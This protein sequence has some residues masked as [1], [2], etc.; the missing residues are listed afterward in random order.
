MT[1][2]ELLI[3]N[4]IDKIISNKL[5]NFNDIGLGDKPFFDDVFNEHINKFKSEIKNPHKYIS[6]FLDIIIEQTKFIVFGLTSDTLSEIFNEVLYSFKTWFDYKKRNLVSGDIINKSYLEIQDELISI[7]NNIKRKEK[8][9]K[10]D[11]VFENERWLVLRILSQEASCKYGSNT[12]WCI[13]AKNDN[14][15]TGFGY[16]EN[17]L[18]Y[19]VIDKKEKVDDDDVLYKM[20]ILIH[21][22]SRRI[23][24]WNAEDDQLT[25][26]KVN[27]VKRFIP[28]IFE[29]IGKNAISVTNAIFDPD[30]LRKFRDNR[31][32]VNINN[33]KI[34]YSHYYSN[35]KFKIEYEPVGNNL[36]HRII[37]VVNKENNEIT[38]R[39]VYDR[40]I[41]DPITGERYYEDFESVLAKYTNKVVLT[42]Q[43][44]I[45]EFRKTF[46]GLFKTPEVKNY[47]KE[48]PDQYF[49][50]IN[51]YS[52]IEGMGGS[53]VP[54]KAFIKAI[55]LLKEK[56][57]QNITTIRRIVDPKLQSSNNVKPLLKSLYNLG[58][59]TL[60][61]RGRN[62]MIVPTPKLNKTPINK[63]I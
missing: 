47:F 25:H 52:D 44:L 39:F 15:F 13:S 54:Q 38:S 53:K 19:F 2:K 57:E 46:F 23:E 62:V 5:K 27:I 4:E 51:L 49:K 21:K 34:S 18:I 9:G 40:V 26:D 24:V 17:N 48:N 37:V 41:N 6:K 29:A 36:G 8:E 56:G 43:N 10:I 7:E 45:K 11:R 42:K 1:L 16:S 55:N 31:N 30:F 28:E 20:A 33:Y 50:S 61:K 63:L 32:I 60:E 3:E 12:R 59:I 14:R 58:L 35:E 22:I